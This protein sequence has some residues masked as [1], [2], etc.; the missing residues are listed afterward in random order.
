MSVFQPVMAT[1]PD[2]NAAFTAR[3]LAWLATLPTDPSAAGTGNP[4]NMGGIP[5]TAQP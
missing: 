3:F 2:S 4:Y 5:A 1:I